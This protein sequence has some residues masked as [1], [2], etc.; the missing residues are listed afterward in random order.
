MTTMKRVVFIAPFGLRPK[1]TV[2]ARMVPLASELRRRGREAIII[3]PPYTNPEDSGTVE[4]VRGVPVKN[5]RLGPRNRALA[6]PILAWRLLHGALDE[7]PTH[8]HLF[9]PKGYGGLA[10]MLFLL[11]RRLRPLPPLFLDTDDWE[12]AGGMNDLHGYSVAEKRLYAFQ[13]Q[14]LP[15]RVRGV[16]C[17]SRMLYDAHTAM[18]IAPDRLL[19]LPNCVDETAP[20][21]GGPVRQRLGIVH[22]T[23]VLLLYTRFFEFRQERLHQVLA[24]V[25]RRVPTVKIL[26]VGKGTRGEEQE[27]VRAAETMGFGRSLAMAGWVEPEAIPGYLAAGD[28]ALYLFD[29]TMVNRAKCPAKLTEI[30]REGVPVVGD[31]VGQIP[32]YTAPENRFLLC[33][34]QDWRQMVD[35]AAALLLNEEKRRK[36]G[37][38]ARRFLLESFTWKNAGEQLDSMYENCGSPHH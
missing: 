33:D 22:D 1:G 15:R 13:E 20:A 28:A 3:A 10:A 11:A 23:P 31:R 5:I 17:A 7:R 30:F 16:T 24:E 25:V 9:K 21:A 34:P 2:M 8:L 36:A 6:A 27:L 12:G 14:W 18:G 32:E 29:D 4:I 37:D 19:Y 35:K 38:A 26:V